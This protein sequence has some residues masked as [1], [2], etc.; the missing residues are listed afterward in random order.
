MFM[1]IAS[2]VLLIAATGGAVAT[3][4]RSRRQAFLKEGTPAHVFAR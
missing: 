3:I 1:F 2:A 4:R